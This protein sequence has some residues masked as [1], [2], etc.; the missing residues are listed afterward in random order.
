MRMR[1]TKTKLKRLIKEELQ[2]ALLEGPQS[3]KQLHARAK[4]ITNKMPSEKV[5]CIRKANQVV[6]TL[7]TGPVHLR[8]A[9]KQAK[10]VR[11]CDKGRTEYEWELLAS[12]IAWAAEKYEELNS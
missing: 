10:I 11:R 7:E 12:D 1:L 8:S 3:M 4:K 2:K 6:A 9:A 5:D